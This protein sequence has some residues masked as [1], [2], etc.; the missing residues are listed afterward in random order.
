[1]FVQELEITNLRIL[2]SVTLAPGRGLNV[3]YGPNGSGKTSVLE[4]LHLLGVGRSFRSRRHNEMVRRGTGGFRVV[5]AISRETSVRRLGLEHGSEGLR[6]RCDGQSITTAS[7]LAKELPLVLLTPDSQRLMTEGANLRRQLLDWCL[8]HVEPGFL[9]VFKRFRRVLKQRNA[10]LRSQENARTV[11]SW[12]EELVESGNAVHELRARYVDVFLPAV[13]SMVG[14][15]L[16]FRVTLEYR[17]GWP[18]GQTLEAALGDSFSSDMA[19]GFTQVGPQRGDL[20]FVL[21]GVAARKL[22]S[23]GEAKLFVAGMIL[24]QAAHFIEHV[25]RMLVVMV[26][27]VASELDEESRRRIFAALGS[28][29]VQTF[30]TTVSR[31]LVESGAWL[32]DAVFHVEQGQV[33]AVV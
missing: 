3:L 29:G 2:D 14:S 4:A 7:L 8:F 27:E 11:R 22:M 1:M 16:S 9:P 23:R 24:A 30:V 15:L 26:D 13:D 5:G 21:D 17:A 32:P 31:G 12:D 6:I 20:A 25:G 18:E 10:A 28:L 19:R 33:R